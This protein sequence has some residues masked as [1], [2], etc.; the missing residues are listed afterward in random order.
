MFLWKRICSHQTWTW[1]SRICINGTTSFLL[2][3]MLSNEIP[4]QLFLLLLCS[5]NRQNHLDSINLVY[6]KHCL[7]CIAYATDSYNSG[8]YQHGLL[9]IQA[10]LYF[11]FVS[12]ILN[13]Y[14]KL[15]VTNFIIRVS[16]YRTN[17]M[18]VSHLLCVLTLNRCIQNCYKLWQKCHQQMLC[19]V[20]Q[21]LFWRKVIYVLH[22]K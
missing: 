11:L 16:R 4:P 3:R 18:A 21:Y 13:A 6:V 5:N 15:F 1:I 20:I 12:N 7:S 14:C 9:Y 19:I 17:L 22:E 10:S 8:G 2:Y